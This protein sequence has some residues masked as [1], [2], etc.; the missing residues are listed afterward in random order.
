M[1]REAAMT[2]THLDWDRE[3]CKQGCQEWIPWY[4]NKKGKIVYGCR[5]GEIPKKNCGQYHCP[6]RKAT[7]QKG[8]KDHA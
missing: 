5:I 6:H 1:P 8:D 7:K 2:A 3:F 4:R